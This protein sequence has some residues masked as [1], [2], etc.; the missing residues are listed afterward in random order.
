MNHISDM[1]TEEYSEQRIDLRKTRSLRYALYDYDFSVMLPP[2][3]NRKEFRLPHERSWGTFNLSNDTA[4]GEYDYDP[5]AFD[6][7]A[8][9]VNLCDM[10]GVGSS[11]MY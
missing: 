3:A 10:H 11:C 1:Y 6:V 8:L 9:G 4:G 2:E 5:F 7:G